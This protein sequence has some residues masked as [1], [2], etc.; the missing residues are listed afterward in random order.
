MPITLGPAAAADVGRMEVRWMRGGGGI[1]GQQWRRPKE[2][3]KRICENCL[4]CP[5]KAWLNFPN[6]STGHTT[7]YTHS[8]TH[9]THWLCACM[10]S[11]FIDAT[12]NEF[13]LILWFDMYGLWGNSLAQALKLLVF[14]STFYFSLFYLFQ[15]WKLFT[16]VAK[17][18]ARINKRKAWKAA[19]GLQ[20]SWVFAAAC[21]QIFLSFS[22][23]QSGA[24]QLLL[25]P[26]V[27][28]HLRLNCF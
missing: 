8:H 1:S 7:H 12:S 10:C 13:S 11:C 4:C 5:S 17:A 23:G 3:R 14:F 20:F 15:L 28:K 26:R 22:V 9:N 16:H 27:N 24:G 21:Q 18:K 2:T 6:A 19:V 25:P